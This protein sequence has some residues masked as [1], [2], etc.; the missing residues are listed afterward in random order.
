[1]KNDV[2][3]I[4]LAVALKG[5]NDCITMIEASLIEDCINYLETGQSWRQDL[6]GK[7]IAINILLQTIQKKIT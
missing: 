3:N 5:S 1:M 7:E 2:K 6:D 4:L